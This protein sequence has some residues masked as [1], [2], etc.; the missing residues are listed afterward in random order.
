[1]F[2]VFAF[3]VQIFLIIDAIIYDTIILHVAN[4]LFVAFVIFPIIYGEAILYFTEKK[5]HLHFFLWEGFISLFLGPY[6]FF[7][8]A[9]LPISVMVLMHVDKIYIVLVILATILVPAIGN[10]LY[11][12][13]IYC[14]E[15]NTTIFG[16]VKDLVTGKKVISDE[17]IAKDKD[18]IEL[19][20]HR[21]EHVQKVLKSDSYEK[22]FHDG[23]WLSNRSND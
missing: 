23:S 6:F 21:F 8:G 14:R 2:Y 22:N 11:Q 18:R 20:Y 16:L 15:R 10:P 3:I 12:L 5:P 13:S 4:F 9:I 1:M 17:I 19:L 7:L